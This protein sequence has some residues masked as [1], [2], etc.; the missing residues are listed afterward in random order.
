[1]AAMWDSARKPIKIK[2]VIQSD[3][4]RR[5]LLEDN[6]VNGNNKGLRHT[7]SSEKSK[8]VVKVANIH[9]EREIEEVTPLPAPFPSP[10][11]VLAVDCTEGLNNIASEFLEVNGNRLWRRNR[12]FYK[13]FEQ[14]DG[15]TDLPFLTQYDNYHVGR[16][17]DKG[18]YYTGLNV[19]EGTMMGEEI[20]DSIKLPSN[21]KS[22]SSWIKGSSYGGPKVG[23]TSVL[24]DSRSLS[25]DV[26]PSGLLERETNALCSRIMTWIDKEVKRNKG[27][28][29]VGIKGSDMRM[30]NGLTVPSLTDLTPS[31]LSASSSSSSISNNSNN[32]NCA[33]S[34][35]ST[36]SGFAGSGD[37]GPVMSLPKL[38]SS[39]RKSDGQQQGKSK[40]S[41]TIQEDVNHMK[42]KRRR[43]RRRDPNNPPSSTSSTPGGNPTDGNNVWGE[44]KLED[45]TVYLMGETESRPMCNIE[46]P[47]KKDKIQ[48]HIFLPVIQ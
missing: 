41:V 42:Q 11:K 1:M 13:S 5:F 22:E 26:I 27:N 44:V 12:H 2:S 14:A 19:N 16:G 39:L 20:I 46:V 45:C 15:K 6:D 30:L 17:R 48:L 47:E 4:T 36:S 35:S 8:I 10:K 40:K 3:G 9:E 21:W 18:L 38:I 31:S 24:R 25:P 32:N 29:P 43:R 33:S 37:E 7:Q 23:S 34:G 28:L